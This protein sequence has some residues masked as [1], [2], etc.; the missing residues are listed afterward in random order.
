MAGGQ[1][2]HLNPILSEFKTLTETKKLL[3]GLLFLYFNGQICNGRRVINNG[4]LKPLKM[5]L[6]PVR[7]IATYTKKMNRNIDRIVEITIGLLTKSRVF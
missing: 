1:Q 6:K 2:P 7:Y 4:S 3:T 5:N